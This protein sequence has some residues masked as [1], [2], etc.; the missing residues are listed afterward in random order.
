MLC[1]GYSLGSVA[2]VVL[3]YGVPRVMVSG[4]LR[5]EAQGSAP[6]SSHLPP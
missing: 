5:S 1:S 2:I 3:P 4:G 6:A